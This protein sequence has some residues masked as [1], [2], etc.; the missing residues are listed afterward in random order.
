[1]EIYLLKLIESHS[2]FPVNPPAPPL[3]RGGSWFLVSRVNDVVS[4]KGL[5]MIKGGL[6]KF[7]YWLKGTGGGGVGKIVFITM[8]DGEY[9]SCIFLIL[10]KSFVLISDV[11]L[12]LK[13]YQLNCLWTCGG[14]WR[15]LFRII[16]RD[17]HVSIKWWAW[18]K[19]S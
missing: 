5:F 12:G 18:S 3:Y 19:T 1:M 13:F 2:C 15:F 10:T 8:V 9:G 6:K 17:A 14:G 16:G 4:S 7:G 11:L